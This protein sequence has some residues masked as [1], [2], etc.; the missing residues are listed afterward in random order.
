MDASPPSHHG[1]DL[2]RT[3]PQGVGSSNHLEQGEPYLQALRS[4]VPQGRAL[5]RFSYGCPGIQ[6]T[7]GIVAGGMVEGSEGDMGHGR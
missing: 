2:A 1:S 6:V 7:G 4:F 5:A 3:L